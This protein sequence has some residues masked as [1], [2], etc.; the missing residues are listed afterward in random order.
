[1][2][3]RGDDADFPRAVAVAPTLGNFTRVGRRD[4]LD[5]EDLGDP[6]YHLGGRHHV[7]HAPAVGGPD[8]HELDEAQ[9]MPAA[10][11]VLRHRDDLGV[12]DAALDDHI[13]LDRREAGRLGGVDALEHAGNRETDVVH[14]A[15]DRI[16]E[17]IEAHGDAL[18][19]GGLECLRALR[20]QGAVGRQ[21]GFDARNRRQQRD[22]LLGIPAQQRFAAGEP[23]L[24]NAVRCEE[25][26][27]P[28]DFLE[29]QQFVAR[30]E[31]VVA[32]EYRLRH[33]VGAAEV[34][35]VGDRYAQVAQPASAGID[36]DGVAHVRS[37]Y[38]AVRNRFVGGD[39]PELKGEIASFLPFRRSTGK[40]SIG[41]HLLRRP[42]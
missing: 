22:Q 32:A 5:R 35:A 40:R 19:A 42:S 11:K 39:Q 31:W 23:D 7:F 28:G 29:R 6:A 8:I 14:A 12:V 26:H 10:A 16:V 25:A 17:R 15:E 33:A 3:H 18:Q 34:A 27:Q 2:G 21:R 20:Q 38:R 1:V 37:I 9:H 41:A 30:Q 4:R 13:D 24:L 36:E